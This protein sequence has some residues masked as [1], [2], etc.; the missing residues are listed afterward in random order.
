[1]KMT[2]RIF[3]VVAAAAA[4]TLNAD[5]GS[6]AAVCCASVPT[7]HGL[8]ASPR[9]LEEHPELLRVPQ[10]VQESEAK[11]ARVRKEL[12]QLTENRALATSPRFVEEHPEL[13]RVSPSAEEAQASAARIQKQLAKLMENRAWAGSPRAREEFPAL[14]REAASD[15]AMG[16]APKLIECGKQSGK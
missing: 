9:Y 4:F 5:A 16:A 7:N 2:N 14:T 13:L 8:A 1:M 3:L 15:T 6:S 12:A 10:S 11:A